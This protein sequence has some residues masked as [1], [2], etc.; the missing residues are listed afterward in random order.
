MGKQNGYKTQCYAR[1]RSVTCHVIQLRI[2]FLVT[3]TTCGPHLLIPL[4]FTKLLIELY[5]GNV[6]MYTSENGE[7]KRF[8]M[9][10]SKTYF[11]LTFPLRSGPFHPEQCKN[12]IRAV[13]KIQ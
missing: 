13:V 8:V 2:L 5:Q 10:G 12:I 6:E 1:S 4:S 11:C 9:V 7:S 3:I